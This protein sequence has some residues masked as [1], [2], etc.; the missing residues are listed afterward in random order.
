M[1]QYATI[2]CSAWQAPHGE[3]P[4]A[5]ALAAVK[6]Q[7][8]GGGIPLLV[9][10]SAVDSPEALRSLTA[11]GVDG[12]ATPFRALHEL[13]AAADPSGSWQSPEDCVASV[14]GAPLAIA[15]NGTRCW[16]SLEPMSSSTVIL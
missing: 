3:V 4:D 9:G 6:R 7:Q 12:F 5:A 2:N 14:L 1:D 11:A 15:V 8:R 16:H 10:T 13:A